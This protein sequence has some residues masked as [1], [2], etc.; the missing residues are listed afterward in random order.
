MATTAAA[1]ASTS[2]SLHLTRFLRHHGVKTVFGVPGAYH[3]DFLDKVSRDPDLNYVLASHEG[4]AAYMAQAY[5]QVTGKFG[6]C[7]V[8]AGGLPDVKLVLGHT[9]QPLV[10]LIVNVADVSNHH[11][12]LYHNRSRCIER[13]YRTRE[14][15][16]RR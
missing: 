8:T 13:S 14:C 2:I 3:I 12:I 5:G 7:C 16:S 1:R 6:C 9:K 10:G 11:E 4:G 15:E